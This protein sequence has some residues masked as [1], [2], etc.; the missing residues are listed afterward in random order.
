MAAILN[1]LLQRNYGFKLQTT[2]KPATKNVNP[3]CHTR[4]ERHV[5]EFPEGYSLNISPDLIQISGEE[6]GVFYG[7]QSLMQLLPAKFDKEA[8]I[9]AAEIKDRP[10]FAYRGMHSM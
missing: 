3:I 10:R 7:L 9:P 1:E 2:N 5:A 4:D 8:K 6:R